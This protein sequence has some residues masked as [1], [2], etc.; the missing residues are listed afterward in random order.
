MGEHLFYPH[1]KLLL[2]LT[3]YVVSIQFVH[4]HTHR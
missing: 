4:L 2:S 3:N 1:I